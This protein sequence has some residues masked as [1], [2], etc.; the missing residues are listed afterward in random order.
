MTRFLAVYASL[1]YL[2]LYM[3]LAV[4][5][6]FS[7]NTSKIAVWQGFTLNWYGGVFRNPALLEGAFNS[8]LIAIVA[9]MVS[10]VMG[11]LAGYVLWKKRLPWLTNS[12]Y[13]SLLS[14]EIVTGV[15]LLAFFQWTFRFWHIQ[16]GMHTVILAH[17]SFSL[18]YVVIVILARLRTFDPALEEAALDLGAKEWQAFWRVTLPMLMP[19]ILAAG[20]LCFTVSFDDYVITSLVAGVNSETLPM[21]IYGMARKGVSPEVNALSVMITVGLGALI[22]MAG[23][24]EQTSR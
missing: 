18:A 12:L 3:P 19:G 5:G 16:L 7:F 2:F 23:R 15:S 10:T 24:L 14:P 1:A 21:I 17:V 13:L 11:T 6:V 8:I 4:L 9:T 22:L 20:L